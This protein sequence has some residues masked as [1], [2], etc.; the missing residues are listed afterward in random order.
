M[1]DG[2]QPERT[3]CYADA[4]NDIHMESLR[5]L[6][7][8]APFN[9]SHEG[10]AVLAEEVDELWD[11]VKADNVEHSIEEAIQVGAMAVR[12]VADMRAKLAGKVAQ[13]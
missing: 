3:A 7:K 5:A 1:I 6:Q 2:P 11:D 13:S 8:F 4:V 9:S 12:Y 10:Y